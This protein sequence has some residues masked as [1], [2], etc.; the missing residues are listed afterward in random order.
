MREVN[1]RKDWKAGVT[2][3]GY[4]FKGQ[5]EFDPSLTKNEKVLL[6]SILEMRQHSIVQ[7][8]GELHS[9][10]LVRFNHPLMKL[11]T[12]IAHATKVQTPRVILVESEL[13]RAA[14]T[15]V[16]DTE[17]I[18]LSKGLLKKLTAGEVGFVAAHEVAH[19]WWEFGYTR[20]ARLNHTLEYFC[21]ALPIYLFGRNDT[22]GTLAKRSPIENDVW[23]P[24]IPDRV[25][26][27]NDRAY[28][29]HWQHVLGA[30]A[31]K[32]NSIVELQKAAL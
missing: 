4:L 18:L 3:F 12:S 24:E 23:H 30:R 19:I 14:H 31:S 21:D 10:E 27:A 26:A 1:I 15:K 2:F 7:L 22:A 25:K 8:F 32:R 6:S 5:R 29:G 11:V 28:V 17:V 20:F 9:F 16:D 13:V